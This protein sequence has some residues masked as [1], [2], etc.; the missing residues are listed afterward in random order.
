MNRG[1]GTAGGRRMRIQRLG[2]PAA[3]ALA[4]IP[5]VLLVS[6]CSSRGADRPDPT[7]SAAL[8]SGAHRA[9]SLVQADALGNTVIGGRD[10]TS[11]SFRFRAAW[12]GSV[13]GLRFYVITNTSERSGYSSGDGGTMRVSLRADSGGR[14]HVPVGRDLAR[15]AFRPLSAGSFP[16][17]R[18]NG[19]PHIVK[20]RLYHVVFQN[21]GSDPGRNYVSINGLFSNARLGH[22]PA[23]PSGMA[24]LE[25]DREDPAQWH[26]RR[27]GPHEYYLPILEVLGGRSSQRS[28]LGYM[29]VWDPKPIGGG[30]GVRQLLQTPANRTTRVA[31]AWLRVR[32]DGSASAPLVL[33]I[34]GPDGQPLASATLSPGAVPTR[35]AGW[36]HVRFQNPIALPAGTNVTLSASSSGGPAYEAFPIRKGVDYG[37]DS[38]TYFNGGYAQFNTGSGW[39][40]WD[41]WGGH[42]EH[43]SDLQFALDL[44]G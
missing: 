41:Q 18:F 44:V 29:E 14:R 34:E 19:R 5:V 31:G 37:F 13:D 21:V 7:A 42:D 10:R 30:A 1:S 28:G 43:D 32:R 23:V 3:V 22:G 40:G 25:R 8:V 17:V 26:P 27:S 11:L 38:S 9:G 16:L 20:G 35:D 36:V 6:T 39:V 15:A 4:A 33:G 24:V 12:T 2:R